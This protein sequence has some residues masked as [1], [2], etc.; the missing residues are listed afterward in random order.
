MQKSVEDVFSKI[1]KMQ[2]GTTHSILKVESRG[3]PET[4]N[5]F[6]RDLSRME[7]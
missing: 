6:L 3:P 4:G 7:K 5:D 1:R 2:V